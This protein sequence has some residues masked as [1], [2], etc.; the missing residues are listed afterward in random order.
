M[1]P[2]LHWT[3]SHTCTESKSV[4]ICNECAFWLI[5][6]LHVTILKLAGIRFSQIIM[7][8]KICHWLVYRGPGLVSVRSWHCIHLHQGYIHKAG[9]VESI[10]CWPRVG[11]PLSRELKFADLSYIASYFGH[12][13]SSP[14]ATMRSK[15]ASNQQDPPTTPLHIIITVYSAQGKDQHLQPSNQYC[16]TAL[17]W[18]G[19][20]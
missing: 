3:V 13:Q 17:E 7:V 5:P 4:V 2:V 12:S 14:P 6:N 15:L 1:R 10:F 11:A 20:N 9:F 16:N 8:I 18:H 19:T